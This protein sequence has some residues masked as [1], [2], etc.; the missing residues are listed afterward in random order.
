MLTLHMRFSLASGAAIL[1]LLAL[2]SLAGATPGTGPQLVQ[3]TGRFV[4]LHADRADGTAIQRW[5]LVDGRARIPVRPPEVWID[6]GSLVRLEGTMQ[7]GQLVLADSASAVT[8][9]AAAAPP[10]A[11]SPSPVMHDTAIIL[12]GFSGG[13]SAAQ[14]PTTAAAAAALAFADP[15]VNPAS[16]NSYYLEQSYGELGFRGKVFGPVTIQGS[17]ATCGGGNPNGPFQTWLTM[18]EALLPGFSESGFQHIVLVF[19]TTSSCGLSGVSGVAEIGGE[20]VWINGDF[21]VRVLA[22]EL[23]HTLGLKHA[24]GAC[25]SAG[26][27]GSCT[28]IAQ[29]GDPFDAMGR[30]SIVRQMSM[31]HKL[32]LGL[33]PASAVKVVGGSGTYHIAPMETLTA[34]PEVLRI[35][36]PGGGS[37]YVE[38]RYPLGF[39]DSQPPG[40]QGVLIHTEAPG[41]NDAN[42]PDA[43]LVDMHPGTPAGWGDAAM[44]VSQA[45]GDPLSGISIQNLGQDAGGATLQISAPRDSVPPSAVAGLTATASGTSAILHWTPASD[46]FQVDSYV[47][48]RDGTPVGSPTTGDFTDTGLLPGATVAYTVAAVDAGG[49]TGPAT[50]V[51][52]TVPDATPP[53]APSLVNA[54]L[55]RDGRVHVAWTAA[56]DNGRIASYA[57][58][59]N[60]VVIATGNALRY[61]DNAPRPGGG[62]TVTYSVTA[63]DLAGNL[64]PAAKAKPLRAALMRKLAA[65]QLKVAR[66]RSGERTLVRVRGRVSDARARCRVRVGSGAWHACRPKADGAFSV[67]LPPQGATPVTLSLRDALGRA[68]LQTLRVP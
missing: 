48:T 9:L 22:H 62:S 11:D 60:G 50:T 27:T 5:M 41:S 30:A 3:R 46:D 68:K 6:P 64:G 10:L 55:T 21:S 36:K 45:F 47:V 39:F 49:N 42:D 7:G 37:Y 35:P 24:G 65:S 57:V 28:P 1:A 38:Y 18:A 15:T 51:S 31:E 29:Y 26:V 40:L 53:G 67:N 56:T 66:V 17:A 12:M 59:R 20:H 4:V 44:D 16:L 58:R 14:L 19:P 34:S 13:P 33:L 54:T 32:A 52:L 61:V 63:R 43:L 2:P 23:G 8:P 25:T